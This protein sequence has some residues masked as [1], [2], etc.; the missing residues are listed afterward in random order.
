MPV[1]APSRSDDSD[2]DEIE[3]RRDFE[4]KR[5]RVLRAASVA[6]GISELV[7]EGADREKLLSLLVISCPTQDKA[8]LDETKKR[9]KDLRSQALNLERAANELESTFASDL[10]FAETWKYLLFLFPPTFSSAPDYTETRAAI[11]ARSKSIRQLAA[12]LKGEAAIF[13]RLAKHYPRL[14]N[15]FYLGRVLRYVSESTG[16]YHERILA[17]ILASAHNELGANVDYS[18]W[19]LQKFRR[20]EMKDLIHPRHF[21]FSTAGMLGEPIVEN[22]LDKS[23]R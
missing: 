7:R 20:R 3:W 23:H 18:E 8:F 22:A 12:M 21:R 14:N 5:K 10:G 1:S 11:K 2:L 4:A 13:A 16:H 17:M 6:S 19:S 9:I 15:K